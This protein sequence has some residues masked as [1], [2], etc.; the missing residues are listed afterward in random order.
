M[1]RFTKYVVII[2]AV[3]MT[4]SSCRINRKSIPVAPVNT[5]INFDMEDLE[6]LGTIQ[7]SSTQSY[8]I[9]IPLGGRP[10]HQGVLLNQGIIQNPIP[11]NRGFNNAMYDAL[12]QM[13]DADFVL[14]LSFDVQTDVQFL[15]RRE[16]LTLK[17]KAYKIKS[18]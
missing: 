3:M 13:P 11:Q 1:K 18:K 5:Q 15:G 12:M 10:Y 17:C 8:F 4:F 9:G 16:Y 6:Y 2:A 14:P 7:G